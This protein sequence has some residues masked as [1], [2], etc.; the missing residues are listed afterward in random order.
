MKN[1]FTFEGWDCVSYA[2]DSA[3]NLKY[4]NSAAVNCTPFFT[5]AKQAL[6]VNLSITQSIV[7]VGRLGT[8][9]GEH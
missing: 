5:D 1:A 6:I 7:T 8:L 2:L 3:P 4:N 9:H